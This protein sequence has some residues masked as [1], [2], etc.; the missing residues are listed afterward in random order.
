MM[1]HAAGGVVAC[2]FRTAEDL[3]AVLVSPGRGPD[4]L[5]TGQPRVAVAGVSQ[6]LG[7]LTFVRYRTVIFDDPLSAA[8]VTLDLGPSYHP[9]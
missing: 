9:P 4:G 1:D 7:I 8:Q 3:V 5:R 6:G 2:A